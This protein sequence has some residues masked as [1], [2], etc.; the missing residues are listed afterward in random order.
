MPRHIRYDAP[1]NNI[2]DLSSRV[3][4]EWFQSTW[5]RVGQGPLTIQGYTVAALPT[6]T[7]FGSVNPTDPFSSIIFIYD[8][9]GGAT[10]AFSDGTN[11]LRVQ[12]RSIAS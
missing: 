6:A 10:L 12:D 5:R 8:E 2:K 3:W 4:S 11:W 9:S 1:P 7:D